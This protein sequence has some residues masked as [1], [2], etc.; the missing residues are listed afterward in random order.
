MTFQS[1]TDRHVM[2]SLY[3]YNGAKRIAKIQWD[4]GYNKIISSHMIQEGMEM[5]PA[6]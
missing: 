5:L 6:K 4:G 3:N 2:E 1:V